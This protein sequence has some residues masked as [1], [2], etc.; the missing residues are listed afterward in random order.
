MKAVYESEEMKS[1]RPDEQQRGEAA[2]ARARELM[3]RGLKVDALID[4]LVDGLQLAGLQ[5]T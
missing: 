5:A 4:D 3:R 2:I 1:L